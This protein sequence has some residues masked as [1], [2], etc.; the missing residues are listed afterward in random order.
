MPQYEL[1]LFDL[2][3]TLIEFHHDFL[4]SQAQKLSKQF[5]NLEVSW[6]ELEET[7]SDFDF[8]RFVEE[9]KRNGF[10]DEFCISIEHQSFLCNQYDSQL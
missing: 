5:L 8:F 2:D 6:D 10:M 7:F 9:E 1:I 4:F 3:G